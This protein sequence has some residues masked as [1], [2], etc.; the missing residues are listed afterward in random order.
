V[1]ATITDSGGMTASQQVSVLITDTAPVNTPPVVTIYSPLG[2]Y[3]DAMTIM[4]TGSA[5]DVPDG[6]VSSRLVWTSSLS[7]V[8]GTGT[9]FTRTLSAGTH[10][11]TASAADNNNQSG[12]GQVTITVTASQPPPAQP[13][14]PSSSISLSARGYKVRGYQRAD[15]SWNG[16]TSSSV[17]VYRDGVAIATTSNN[18]VW[19]DQ[20]NAKGAAS[21]VYKVCNSGTSTCSNDVTVSF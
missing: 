20:I 19:T 2:T 12:F 11:I 18:N 21:Y 10:V 1:S 9:G 6:D 16:A 5:M 13:A 4:F 17:D 14:P 15:L 8:V 7:G 3:T